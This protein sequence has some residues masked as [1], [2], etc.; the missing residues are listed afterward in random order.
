MDTVRFHTVTPF[1]LLSIILLFAG[2]TH[3][4]DSHFGRG[5][6]PPG[7][8]FGAASAA[9]QLCVDVLEEAIGFCFSLWIKS[10][11]LEFWLEICSE[12]SVG[13]RWALAFSSGDHDVA[14]LFRFSSSAD[15]QLLIVMTSLLMSSQLIPYLAHLLNC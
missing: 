2:A 15:G 1:L 11:E 13:H 4:I 8:T 3:A 7:F 5:S 9:Y 6:F 10:G 14:S 12:V